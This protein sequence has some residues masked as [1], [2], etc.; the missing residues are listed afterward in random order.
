V[1]ESFERDVEEEKEK[2]QSLEHKLSEAETQEREINAA[3]AASSRII[4]LSKGTGMEELDKLQGGIRQSA[5]SL[6]YL[7][8][9]TQLN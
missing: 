7:I 4:E 6:R 9:F 5:S 1:V 3:I 2:M 8:T